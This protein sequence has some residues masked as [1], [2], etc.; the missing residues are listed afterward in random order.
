MRALEFHTL[1]DPYEA[2][3][4]A[5]WAVVLAMPAVF[6]EMFWSAELLVA[7]GSTFGVVLEVAAVHSGRRHGEGREPQRH[8]PAGHHELIRVGGTPLPGRS[9][10]LRDYT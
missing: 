10:P 9:P 8:R 1:I 7:L 6:A 2:R 5:K 3:C 4:G